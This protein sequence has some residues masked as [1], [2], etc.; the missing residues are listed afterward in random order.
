MLKHISRYLLVLLLLFTAVLPCLAQTDD[1]KETGRREKIL[2][3]HSDITVNP[4]ATLLVQE[5]IRVLA[6]HEQIRHGIYRDFPT[7]YHDRQGHDYTV[8]FSLQSVT[9]NDAAEPYHTQDI[10]NGVR[11]YIGDANSLVPE[12]E[13]TYQITYT[14]NREA[15]FLPGS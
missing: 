11:I 14:V 8:D 4:D 5:T 12:G 3:Y 1:N 2:A 15:R 10:T 6:L 7:K 9:R 13:Q